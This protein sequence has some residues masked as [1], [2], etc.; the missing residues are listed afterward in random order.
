TPAGRRGGGEV[1]TTLGGMDETST[2]VIE[3]SGLTKRYG[4]QLAVDRVDLSV[5]RGEVYGFLGPNGAGKTTTLRIIT[6]LIAPTSGTVRV[7]GGRPG[8]PAVLA[9]TGALIESPALYPFLSGRDNLRVLARYAGV[10]RDRV[11]E[12]LELVELTDRAG[13]RF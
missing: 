12:V 7:F 11:D 5:R 4:E 1:R 2:T 8:D 13:D 9:R 6:G 10:P 3:V